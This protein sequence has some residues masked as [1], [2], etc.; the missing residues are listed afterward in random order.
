MKRIL[1][2]AFAVM[3]ISAVALAAEKKVPCGQTVNIKAVPKTHYH[4]LRWSDNS[5]EA[6]RTVTV[7]EAMTL[8]AYFEADATYSLTLAVNDASLG[9]VTIKS[10]GKLSYYEGD[11]VV[12]LAS[13]KDGCRRFLYW[14][15]D[16]SNTIPVRTITINAGT[17]SYKAVFEMLEYKLII[18][19]DDE[20]MGTVEFVP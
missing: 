15:D 9:E 13:A 10:G 2:L 3:A 20:E 12:I 18:Q 11:Q 17:N 4:F 7:D 8:K 14:D 16:H 19:S 6:Q 1:S 5:T